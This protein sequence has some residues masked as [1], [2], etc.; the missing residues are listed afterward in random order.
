ML[1]TILRTYKEKATPGW[2]MINGSYFCHTLELSKNLCIPEGEYT[3]Q[4]TDSPRFKMIMPQI[5]NVR[6]FEGIRIHWGNFIKDT[7]GCPL[8]GYDKGVDANGT[9]S[10]YRSKDAFK[11]LFC[12]L[13]KAKDNEVLAIE[14]KEEK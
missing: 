4:L 9:D 5:M 6:G 3:I 1:L 8:V 10:V 14:I 12:A 11:A 13:D 7:K 2:L